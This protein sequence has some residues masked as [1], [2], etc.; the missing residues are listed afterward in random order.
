M[1]Q[2][3]SYYQY[4]LLSI[5]LCYTV[6]YR[7]AVS[8]AFLFYR[9][10]VQF[11]IP[12]IEVIIMRFRFIPMI[13][14]LLT[15]LSQSFAAP[16]PGPGWADSYSVGNT[17]YCKSQY[18]HAVEGATVGNTK[19]VYS[20][21]VTYTIK[22]VCDLITS[23][24]GRP[25]SNGQPL[26]ND[27]HC[28]HGPANDA[29]FRSADYYDEL[30]CPGRV[31]QGSAGCLVVGPKWPLDQVFGAGNYNYLF[32]CNDPIDGA[33]RSE[34]N[35]RS[36]PT[37]ESHTP[38]AAPSTNTAPTVYFT[39]PSSDFSIFQ[40]DAFDIE[41]RASDADGTVRYVHLYIGTT[42]VAQEGAAP[43][44]WRSSATRDAKLANLGVGQYSITAVATDDAGAKTIS[45]PLV[46]TV[47]AVAGSGSTID[48]T[49]TGIL[50]NQKW[51][52]IASTMSRH[53]PVTHAIDNSLSTRWT[54]RAA[55][56]DTAGQFFAIDLNEQAVISS[57]ELDN[58][59]SPNDYPRSYAVWVASRTQSDWSIDAGDG[60]SLVA[61]GD[62]DLDGITTIDFAP[63]QARYI[64]I[65]QTGNDASQYYWWSIHDLKIIASGAANATVAPA[66]VIPV[67]QLIYF[68]TPTHGQATKANELLYVE[69]ELTSPHKPSFI[70]LYVNGTLVRVER[71]HRYQWGNNKDTAAL[72][73][74]PGNHTL[75]A[76]AYNNNG[77]VIAEASVQVLS[78]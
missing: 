36:S 47:V 27:V 12:F 39:Q 28:G 44:E 60:W 20:A 24:V 29:Y 57:I 74:P 70:E 64:K 9:G 26:Y 52:M 11:V 65:E 75:T 62:G 38:I 17:C 50:D 40:G 22:Q 56:K 51:N 41:V 55:Q 16:S 6:F 33:P 69:V 49:P 23:R 46:L 30:E 8:A 35:G 31:D 21:G 14:L 77:A 2:P 18:D 71:H 45:D 53:G 78:Q 37:C 43:Y 15:P 63:T 42:L 58:V 25:S 10:K 32:D 34:F 59:K 3:A 61:E 48:A 7:R 1:I 4:D 66:E 67:S 13:L 54:T 19:I 73:L 5:H 72:T 76:I 68:K